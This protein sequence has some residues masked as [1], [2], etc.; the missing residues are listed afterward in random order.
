MKKLVLAS[1]AALVLAG[2]V[3]GTGEVRANSYRRGYYRQDE[4]GPKA[5]LRYTR[6]N[7]KLQILNLLKEFKKE[8]GGSFAFYQR[9]FRTKVYQ[10]KRVEDIDKV[11]DSFREEL[12][13]LRN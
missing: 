4:T 2:A 13:Q 10:Q 11:L 1:A 12:E 6:D 7:A 3:V 9:K 8:V 5:E